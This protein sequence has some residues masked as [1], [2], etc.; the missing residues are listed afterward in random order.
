MDK[1]KTM[2]TRKLKATLIEAGH[3]VEAN[4]GQPTPTIK[5]LNAT[6]G[7][8]L[9]A[10]DMGDM[11]DQSRTVKALISSLIKWQIEKM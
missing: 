7:S 9:I 6:F 5:Q 1:I 11:K 2:Y 8:L 4:Q 10:A 3:T